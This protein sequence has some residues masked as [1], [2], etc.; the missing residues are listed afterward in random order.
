MTVPAK[1]SKRQN[2]FTKYFLLFMGILL[3]A[4]AILGF[5][6]I[7]IVNTYSLKEKTSI[8]SENTQSLSRAVAQDM[9]VNDMNNAYSFDKVMICE[10]LNMV[11][12]CIDADVFVCDTGGSII[13]C[14]EQTGVHQEGPVPHRCPTGWGTPL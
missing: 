4:F 6:L 10:N 3:T 11:S 7:G 12:G 9:I 8:L 5:V 13:M 14:K 1:R 2:L